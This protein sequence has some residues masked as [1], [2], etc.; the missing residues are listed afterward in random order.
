MANTTIKTTG[1]LRDLLVSKITDDLQPYDVTI[2]TMQVNESI[3]T[4][5]R[6]AEI[7]KSL[8]QKTSDFGKLVIGE[9]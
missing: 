2:L 5:M 3:S 4:E 7:Q 8:G 9:E 1:Q 6:T